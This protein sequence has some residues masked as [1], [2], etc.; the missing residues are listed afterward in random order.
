MAIEYLY[1]VDIINMK[2]YIEIK[3]C[4][5]NEKRGIY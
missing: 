1:T 3:G 4:G 5:D 2:K